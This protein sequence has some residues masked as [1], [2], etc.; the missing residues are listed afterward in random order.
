MG[1]EDEVLKPLALL[2]YSCFLTDA[3]P[4]FK[5]KAE[6]ATETILQRWFLRVGTS[7]RISGK[8][9]NRLF[10]LAWEAAGSLKVFVEDYYC[11]IHT[12]EAVKR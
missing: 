9:W 8:A 4:C 10:C 7:G 6:S 5:G 11:N 12:L 3:N 1:K 2:F